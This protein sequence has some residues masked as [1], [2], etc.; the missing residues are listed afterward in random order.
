MGGR[1]VAVWCFLFGL[2]AGCVCLVGLLGC[3]VVFV[4]FC[5]I[6]RIHS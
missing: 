3:V 6:G 5:F 4:L 1:V 2:F